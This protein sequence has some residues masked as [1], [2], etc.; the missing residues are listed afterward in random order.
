MATSF[1][2]CPDLILLR[3]IVRQNVVVRT[4]IFSNNRGVFSGRGHDFVAE[5]TKGIS[6]LSGIVLCGSSFTD[7]SIVLPTGSPLVPTDHWFTFDLSPVQVG[8]T[9]DLFKDRLFYQEK[10]KLQN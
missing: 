7:L 9:V 8:G 1:R 5:M 2:L 10:S 4:P 6:D 3:D